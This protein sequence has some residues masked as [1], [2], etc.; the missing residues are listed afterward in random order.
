M[1][2]GIGEEESLIATITT[3]SPQGDRDLVILADVPSQSMFGAPEREWFPNALLLAAAPDL[4]EMLADALELAT[5]CYAATPDAWDQR[6][7]KSQRW[8]ERTRAALAKA[9]GEEAR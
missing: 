9:R 2:C 7:R 8:E 1:K 4:Y 6:Q 3:D 5:P